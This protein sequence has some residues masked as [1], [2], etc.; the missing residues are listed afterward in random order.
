VTIV[1]LV[2][3]AILA[4]TRHN[5]RADPIVVRGRSLDAAFCFPAARAVTSGAERLAN[6]SGAPVTVSAAR[7][8]S[9]T[10]MRLVDT[11]VV[12]LTGPDV[13]GMG[14][15]LPTSAGDAAAQP[16]AND[17]KGRQFVPAATIP[18]A[19]RYPEVKA[20]QL[21]FGAAVTHPGRP[22]TLDRVVVTFRQGHR[23]W[24]LTSRIRL[25]V[26]GS[27]QLPARC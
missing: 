24:H 5:A 12:A 6:K 4:G 9:T 19:R 10:D 2:G 17:W 22:A 25:V 15:G 13:I 23:T 1:A 18:P 27:E 20:W 14:T 26:S 21:V 7:A 8:V 16:A 3:V 11:A